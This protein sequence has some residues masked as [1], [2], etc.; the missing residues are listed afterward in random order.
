MFSVFITVITAGLSVLT[1]A[2][3]M[4]PKSGYTVPIERF[5][6]VT[7]FMYRGARPSQ[8][9][10]GVLRTLGVKTILNIDNEAKPIAIERAWAQSLGIR[11]VSIPLS[12]FLAPSDQQMDQVF[13]VIHDPSN[14]PIFLHCK[15]GEDRTGLVVGLYRYYD[16]HWAAKAAYDEM[17]SHGFHKVL[18]GLNY[19]FKEKTGLQDDLLLLGELQ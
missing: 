1:P 3:A 10:M 13:K 7:P 6:R 17:L 2:Q 11:F 14:Y 12:G 16:E 9:G 19:Y 18:L 5:A 8:E 4:E 15:H